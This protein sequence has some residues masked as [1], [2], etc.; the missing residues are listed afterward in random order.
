MNDANN[1]QTEQEIVYQIS[2][3]GVEVELAGERAIGEDNP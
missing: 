3:Q 1:P 2:E